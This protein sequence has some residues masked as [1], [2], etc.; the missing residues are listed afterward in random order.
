MQIAEVVAMRATCLKKQVGTVLVDK[1]GHIIG[2][3]YNGQP[4]GVQH[5]DEKSPCLASID[6]MISCQA[7]HSEMNALMQCHDV[8]AI[9]KVYCT[10]FPCD[11]CMMMIRNTG[12]KELIYLNR[13]DA[14]KEI[15]FTM[16]KIV[17]LG[18]IRDGVPPI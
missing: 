8:G 15:T 6:P 7:I 13:P 1:D 3:G 12:C 10:H 2:T 16:P 9:E 5:C 14:V 11:K 17:Q 18:R 4:K